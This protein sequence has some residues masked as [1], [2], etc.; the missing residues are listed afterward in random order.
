MP[1]FLDCVQGSDAWHTY[2]AGHATASR[3]GDILAGKGAREAYMWEL[4][5]ERL[6]GGPM[7]DTGGVAKAW[8][9]DAEDMARRAYM[10][11]TGR[12]VKQV[13]FAV[14][15]RIKWC[16]ASS[17]G[18]ITSERGGIEIKS[19]FNSGIHVRTLA[20]GMPDIHAAQTQGNLWVLDLDWIDF[21]SYDPALP[22]PLDLYVQRIE[23]RPSEIKYLEGEVKK[24]LAE[25]NIAYLDLKNSINRT[26]KI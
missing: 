18:L 4:V 12:M 10:V 6:I 23:R 16:G 26:I 14:H 9:T 21:I 8:G 25:A 20:S 3:F 17:D 5:A 13:G 2:R 1:L 24:F 15:D 11:R 7:R 19:P 22:D